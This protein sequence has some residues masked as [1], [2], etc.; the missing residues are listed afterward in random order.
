MEQ[1]GA[2]KI[3]D[4]QIE[5]L[6]NEIDSLKLRHRKEKEA[7]ETELEEKK[8]TIMRQAADL[9]DLTHKKQANQGKTE[10]LEEKIKSL[11]E[12]IEMKSRKYLKDIQ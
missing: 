7:L 9:K 12:E 2:R 4:R 10:E 11:I 1:D 6:E 8:H 5:N 3:H